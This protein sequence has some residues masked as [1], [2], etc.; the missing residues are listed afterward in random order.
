MAALRFAS[1]EGGVAVG[2]A[3]VLN[4]GVDAAPFDDLSGG[5]GHRRS[6]KEEP[7]ILF[8]E[9]AQVRFD[10]DRLEGGQHELPA[11]EQVGQVLGVDGGLPAVANRFV[12]GEAGV[13]TPVMIEEVD[14]AAR[15]RGPYQAWERIDE[16]VYFAFHWSLFLHEPRHAARISRDGAKLHNT[17][18]SGRVAD[19]DRCDFGHG[20]YQG[21]A[22]TMV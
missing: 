21:M 11:F 7:A 5:V 22:N 19:L 3:E 20:P 9:A 17:L 15:E 2:E 12:G 4:V 6:P 16:P 8:V 18:V 1:A 13:L 14:A 10:F